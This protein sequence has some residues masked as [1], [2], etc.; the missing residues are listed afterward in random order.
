M[1]KEVHKDGTTVIR[2]TNG[3][4]ETKFSGGTTA[5]FHAK[6]QVMQINNTADG[7]TLFEY[8]NRQIERH[9]K[10]GSKAILFADGTRQ[11]I[12]AEGKVDTAFVKL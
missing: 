10:D 12:S 4:V 11:R 5:Y 1:R 2:F 8:P 6:D 3:D 9:Y 7:S